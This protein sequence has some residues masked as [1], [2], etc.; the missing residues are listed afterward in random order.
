MFFLKDLAKTSHG[1]T[2]YSLK[3]VLVESDIFILARVFK[4]APLV[5]APAWHVFKIWL[6][7]FMGKHHS[8]KASF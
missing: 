4:S 3:T 1:E 6:K 5:Q 7:H 8:L 2:L